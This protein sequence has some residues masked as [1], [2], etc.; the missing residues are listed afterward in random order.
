MA[1]LPQLTER[2]MRLPEVL[3]VGNVSD[4]VLEAGP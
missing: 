2:T 3:L 4:K 1:V